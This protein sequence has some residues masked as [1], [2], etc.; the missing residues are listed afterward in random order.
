MAGR[1]GNCRRMRSSAVSPLLFLHSAITVITA[2][3]GAF[4]LAQRF[5]IR[6]HAGR[7]LTP[8]SVRYD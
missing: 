4:G 2:R 8:S 6:A 3:S 5:A 7:W 1:L